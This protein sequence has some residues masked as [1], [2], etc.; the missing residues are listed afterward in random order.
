MEQFDRILAQ[1]FPEA[2]SVFVQDKFLGFRLR[3]KQHVLL[4]EVL[5]GEQAGTSVVKIGPL[6]ALE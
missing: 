2:G 5:G 1:T 4:V 3:E 6:A